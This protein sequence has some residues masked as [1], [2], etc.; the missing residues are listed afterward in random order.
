MTEIRR[1]RRVIDFVGPEDWVDMM[2]EKSL[3]KEE[4][5]TFQVT[6]SARVEL[7]SSGYVPLD[8]GVSSKMEK[9]DQS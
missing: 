1:Y 5:T 3:L 8:G 2:I 4:Q 7:V 6:K 9:G